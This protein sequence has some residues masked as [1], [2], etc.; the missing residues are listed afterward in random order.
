MTCK[1]LQTPPYHN[2]YKYFLWYCVITIAC[3]FLRAASSHNFPSTLRNVSG[4]IHFFLARVFLL[5]NQNTGSCKATT[6]NHNSRA[7]RFSR[8]IFT[9]LPLHRMHANQTLHTHLGAAHRRVL[10]NKTEELTVKNRSSTSHLV[11]VGLQTP[12][13]ICIQLTADRIKYSRTARSNRNQTMWGVPGIKVVR[14]CSLVCF[15]DMHT[16]P[17]QHRHVNAKH[18]TEWPFDAIWCGWWKTK[19]KREKIIFDILITKFYHFPKISTD[20]EMLHSNTQCEIAR[21]FDIIQILKFLSPVFRKHSLQISF[22]RI[23]KILHFKNVSGAWI[24][25]S[26]YLAESLF[27]SNA[28]LCFGYFFSEQAI[29]NVDEL[30]G[31]TWPLIVWAS[32][33]WQAVYSPHKPLRD[34]ANK[35]IDAKRP[36]AVRR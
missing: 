7:W 35:Q 22:W 3:L 20:T 6:R 10:E 24:T 23:T 25:F 12:W 5:E 13:I 17:L 36:L 4:S 9:H 34:A 11:P 27:G 26:K 18:A 15:T 19:S 31:V 32:S 21:F 29:E 1:Y 30:G 14:N 8:S 28:S 16:E 33:T 2:Y